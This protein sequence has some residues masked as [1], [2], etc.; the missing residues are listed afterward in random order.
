MGHM[1]SAVELDTVCEV[2]HERLADVRTE[3]LDTDEFL[4]KQELKQQEDI[5]RRLLAKLEKERLA[6]AVMS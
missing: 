1:L 5:L 2:L 4:Y 3:I 6:P